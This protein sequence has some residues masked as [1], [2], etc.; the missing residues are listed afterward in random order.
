MTPSNAFGWIMLA[1]I[2]SVLFA[3]PIPH[4][5]ALR[6]LLLLSLIFL[7]FPQARRFSF[8]R[9]AAPLSPWLLLALWIPLQ[10]LFISDSTAASLREYLGHFLLPLVMLVTGV[11]LSHAVVRGDKGTRW[12]LV[13]MMAP[14]LVH[15]AYGE[16]ASF[17]AWLKQG[18]PLRQM[19]LTEGPDKLNYLTLSL[20]ALLFGWLGERLLRRRI[21]PPFVAGWFLLF[22]AALA[23]LYVTYMRLGY[24]MVLAMGVV[25]SVTLLWRHRKKLA[26]RQRVALALVLVAVIGAV[27]INVRQDPRWQTLFDTPKTVL[28]S[29]ESNL[30]WLDFKGAPPRLPNGE[31]AE[32]SNY[33]RL[34]WYLE[35]ARMIEQWPLGLGYSRN[36]FGH[37]LKKRYGR[38]HGHSHSGW[39]DLA[40]G[41]GIPALLLWIAGLFSMGWFA[42]RH[43][44]QAPLP[45]FALLLVLVD[46]GLRSAVDSVI[47]DHM[48]IQFMLTSG[49]L[50]GWILALAQR[51]ENSSSAAIT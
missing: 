42:L 23:G 11:A 10:A 21:T 48:F 33:L 35:G 6:N 50:T 46:F 41:A 5:I 44:E 26:P 39:I 27:A 38:G 20:L 28:A 4:T 30:Y 3:L 9:L 34:S 40:L 16:W 37:G 32:I 2:A 29:H 24:L 45:A 17:S 22:L 31:V 51:A 14:L 7:A 15:L 19:G 47:R 49:L 36:A 43:L 8:S 25:F 18:Y 13:A 12:L 1:L